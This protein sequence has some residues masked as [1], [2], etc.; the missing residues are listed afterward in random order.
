MCPLYQ[1]NVVSS[2]S[3][4]I[5]VEF[6]AEAIS[7]AQPTPLVFQLIAV[8]KHYKAIEEL[9]LFAMFEE[10][11]LFSFQHVQDRC[12][13]LLWQF[14]EVVKLDPSVRS[15]LADEDTIKGVIWPRT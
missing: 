12:L 9:I 11:F 10:L 3:N 4:I 8:H 2:N 1:A 5:G 15:A 13:Q 14:I 6:E 7:H